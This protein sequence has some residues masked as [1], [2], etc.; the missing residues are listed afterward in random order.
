MGVPGVSDIMR[1]LSRVFDETSDS[2]CKDGVFTSEGC[3]TEMEARK[4][5]EKDR[6]Y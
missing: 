1:K 3:M 5:D 6:E 2:F 4:S